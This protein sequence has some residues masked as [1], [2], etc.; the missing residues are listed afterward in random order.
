MEQYFFF[1]FVKVINNACATQAILSILLNLSHPDLDLGTMLTEFKD[2]AATLDPAVSCCR[3]C[4]GP[5]SLSWFVLSGV[6][7]LF[8]FL[9]FFWAI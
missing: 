6:C 1:P 4:T 2:F 9:F 7:L 3:A 5:R 8:F